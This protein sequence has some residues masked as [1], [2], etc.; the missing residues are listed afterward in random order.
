[1]RK[2]V[3]VLI[4][5]LLLGLCPAAHA[6]KQAAAAPPAGASWLGDVNDD[7]VLG[8]FDLLDLLKILGG[9]TAPTERQRVLA[10]VD[11]SADGAIGVFDLLALLKVLAG[12][13]APE[14]VYWGPP[15]LVEVSPAHALPGDTVTLTFQNLHGS[16]PLRLYLR[17]AETELLSVRASAATFVAPDS[18]VGGFLTVVSGGDTLGT[19]FLNLRNTN[20][21]TLGGCRLF[22]A[23]NPWNQPVEGFPVHA[24][25]DNIIRTIGSAPLHPDMSAIPYN[26][27]GG[28]Q[29]LVPI[30]MVTYPNDSDPGPYPVP[31]DVLIEGGPSSTGDRHSLILD[32]TNCVLYELGRVFPNPPGWSAGCGAI[33]NLN[34]NAQRPDT[35]TSVDAAGLPMLPGVVQYDEVAAGEVNHAIR[36]TVEVTRRAYVYPASHYASSRTD[37]YLPP[38]G[39]R[40]RLKKSYDISRLTGQSQVIAQALK[41]YGM[42]LADNGGDWFFSG[43]VSRKWN[44]NELDQLKTINGSNFEVVDA[45]SMVVSGRGSRY[46]IRPFSDVTSPSPG[47]VFAAGADIPIRVAASDNDGS[48][49]RVEFF[50]DKTKLGEVSSPPYEFNWSGASAGSHVISARSTDNDGVSNTSWGVPVTVQ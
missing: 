8:V 7:G 15:S 32:S 48:V 3:P 36:F 50:A 38:M 28:D 5:F 45:E 17:E 31:D 37:P 9:A 16:A 10:N 22:P 13:L 27:V 26:V 4:L 2:T 25:S 24:L 19:R 29:P 43:G 46:R 6:A 44:D 47:A 35:W 18:F 21:H 41:K 42:I 39:L 12:V 40:V 11:K 33:F 14:A 20:V 23:D 49:V 1:M 34:S 30:T